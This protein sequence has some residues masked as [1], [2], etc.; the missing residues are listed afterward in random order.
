MGQIFS[1]YLLIFFPAYFA[2]VFVPG[3]FLL[4]YLKRPFLQRLVM[5]SAA[6]F[7]L[8]AIAGFIF[9]YLQA[10]WLTYIYVAVFLVLWFRSNYKSFKKFRF[11]LPKI[12]WLSTAIVVVGVVSN[13]SAVWFMGVKTAQ[14]VYFC[15]RGIPDAIFHLSL[16]DQLI[17]NFPPFEGGMAGVPV[18]NYHFFSNLV[19]AEFSRVFKIPFI[20]LQFQFLS[21][22][23]AVMLG[24]GA[25]SLAQILN[26]KK[27][28]AR[29][30]A[31]FLYGAGDLL[32]LLYAIR[33]KGVN[34]DVQVLDD[35][36]KL[37][38]GPPR[39]FSIVLFFAGLSIFSLFLKRK[40]M[41]TGVLSAIVFGSLLSFKVYAGIFA[42]F[43][44]SILAIYWLLKREFRS[45][46]VP[47]AA[48]VIALGLYLPINSG[49]GGFIFSG[50]WRF[51]HFIGSEAG[52]NTIEVARQAAS[53][54][55]NLFRVIYLEV[56]FVVLYFIFLFGTTL[57]GL[58]Q[59]KKSLSALPK[60]LHIFLLSGIGVSI[61][62]GSLFVQKTGGT[63]SVQ[64]IISAYIVLSI[65][66][67]ISLSYWSGKISKRV[68]IA[69]ICLVIL[70]IC[71]RSFYEVFSNF[72]Y[73]F[74]GGGMVV[75]NSELS[76]LN[77]LKEKT[78]PGSIVMIDPQ[79][80]EVESFLYTSFLA[81]RPI[82]LAG[83]GVLRDHGQDTEIRELETS[84][85]FGG[86]FWKESS[87]LLAKNDV[88]YILLPK[89]YR[90][91]FEILNQKVVFENEDFEVVYVR[92]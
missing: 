23:L 8:W 25:F 36:T 54:N 28:F 15:C 48:I 30:L 73:L 9:G 29:F 64:F 22:V 41:R 7:S 12:D 50:L 68:K 35:A 32:F 84:V 2:A 45:L 67:A 42:L 5:A 18:I 71:A 78:E 86:R 20:P 76:A 44:L 56:L 11:L 58:I 57:F 34:F 51:H 24:L 60:E 88:S 53:L 31:I 49:A 66:A 47:V 81:D 87:E 65:Y 14:G 19:A 59:S 16:T 26:L 38:A 52:L 40:D 92:Q 70:L 74:G 90:P 85:V 82:F 3:D 69:A 62:I 4:G 72:K 17:K 43:G 89:S 80:A 21:L 13:L 61:I 83:A 77:Y 91:R 46:T 75:N 10:R 63:N 1:P 39:A 33:G 27:S 55:H 79:R 37:L 6:G